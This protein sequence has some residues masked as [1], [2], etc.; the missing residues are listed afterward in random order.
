MPG[1]ELSSSAPALRVPVVRLSRPATGPRSNSSW[2][3][4]SATYSQRPHSQATLSS[5]CSIC[6][7]PLIPSSSPTPKLR[8]LRS[9]SSA[10]A[11]GSTHTSSWSNASR[12]GSSMTQGQ[13]RGCWHKR[14]FS[15]PRTRPLPTLP[16]SR[17]KWK[18]STCPTAK[19]PSTT[20]AASKTTPTMTTRWNTSR[21]MTQ[22]MRTTTRRSLTTM[23]MMT[24]TR[25][26]PTAT[27]RWT[28]STRLRRRPRTHVSSRT[29]PSRRSC[30][31]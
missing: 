31:G 30:E 23:T 14:V 3:P 17:R 15:A 4:F 7:T 28:T 2:L 29:R 12:K 16:Y 19:N 6:S 9:R 5:L 26:T 27:T 1:F 8:R 11:T 20:R 21:R 25:I 13:A 22:W 24:T 10:T 18:A